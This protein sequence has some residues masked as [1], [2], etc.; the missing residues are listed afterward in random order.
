M[1][2][3]GCLME[4]KMDLDDKSL[5]TLACDISVRPSNA[6]G[7]ADALPYVRS[8]KVNGN[9]VIV[10][11]DEAGKAVVESFIDA[12]RLCCTDAFRSS[13]KSELRFSD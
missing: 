6:A 11:F 4:V 8:K 10:E 5:K 2:N 3:A 1:L 7:I 13:T 12:E 9:I